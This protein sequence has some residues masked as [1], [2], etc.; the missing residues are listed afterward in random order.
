MMWQSGILEKEKKKNKSKMMW[1]SYNCAAK[2]TALG[3]DCHISLLVF[4]LIRYS[5]SA[6]LDV[7]AITGTQQ[8]QVCRSTTGITSLARIPHCPSH[9]LLVLLSAEGN[10]I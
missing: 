6:T 3:H 4:W 7:R 5:S 2:C 1:Q 9:H 10:G 8:K